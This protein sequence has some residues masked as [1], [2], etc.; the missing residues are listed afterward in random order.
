MVT[1]PK[2]HIIKAGLHCFRSCCIAWIKG[3]P[4]FITFKKWYKKND[5]KSSQEFRKCRPYQTCALNIVLWWDFASAVFHRPPGKEAHLLG[6]LKSS[7]KCYHVTD[8]KSS[9]RQ[10]IRG[11]SYWS[12]TTRICFIMQDICIFRVLSNK[13]KVCSDSHL[14]NQQSYFYSMLLC[15]CIV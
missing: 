10:D 13:F 3:Y 5:H 6:C 14:G 9:L 8:G 15:I 1:L 11:C 2:L 12:L 7:K 4:N